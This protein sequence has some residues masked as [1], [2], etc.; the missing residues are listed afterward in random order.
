MLKLDYVDCSSKPYLSGINK[1]VTG[2]KVLEKVTDEGTLWVRATNIEGVFRF[3]LTDETGYSWSSRTGVLNKEFDVALI[4]C[5]YRHDDR[6]YMCCAID[7]AHLDEILKGTEYKLD[8]VPE[9]WFENK[10]PYYRP[11]KIS[12]DD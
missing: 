3:G 4:E 7:F 2:E 10:E 1:L 6:S 11:R 9:L 8:P 12:N 5:Y